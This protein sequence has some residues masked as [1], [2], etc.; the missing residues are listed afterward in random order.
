MIRRGNTLFNLLP[1]KWFK[2][3]YKMGE[4]SPFEKAASYCLLLL[5]LLLF[6][7]PT[8]WM[9]T[10]SLKTA[11]DVHQIPQIWVPWPPQ[12]GN[13][14]KVFTDT[15]FDRFM[16]NTSWYSIISV[17][18]TVLTSSLVAFGF[19]RLRARGKTFLFAIV[20]STMMIPSQVVMIPQYLIFNKLDWIDSYLPMIIPALAGSSFFIFL[21]RQFYLGI[22]RELD[23]AVKIDGGSYFTLYARIILPLSVPAMITAALL[24]FMHR[25]N[26]LMGPLIYLNTLNKY[27][28]S[29]GLANFTAA[30]GDTPWHL[31]MAASL[32]AV[33]PPLI[34]F[35]IGQKY[36]IRGIVISGSKG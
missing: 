25:W 1:Q 30:Y 15:P 28:L 12:W 5:F 4:L 33:L 32:T 17:I 3:A 22:S 29:L 13:Y 21:L 24:E 27:P 31:L 6:A 9:I 11:G 10:T 35:F 23:E 18:A 19:A 36:F 20:L 34:L 7:F 26:D 16:W 2:K 14:M 8:L